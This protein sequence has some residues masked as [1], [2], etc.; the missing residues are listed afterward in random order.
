[1]AGLRST[2]N[3][4]M[5]RLWAV[6]IGVAMCLAACGELSQ[7]TKNEAAAQATRWGKVGRQLQD[8]E[9]N[10]PAANQA[11]SQ[12]TSAFADAMPSKEDSARHE[13]ALRYGR[14]LDDACEAFNEA[15]SLFEAVQQAHTEQREKH[16]NFVQQ[17]LSNSMDPKLAQSQLDTYERGLSRVEQDL[18][19]ALELY[20][21][22]LPSYRQASQELSRL[23]NEF[24]VPSLTP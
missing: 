15:Q 18:E 16:A 6:F 20:Q 21:A 8:L 9:R 10:L 19:K 2:I 3:L 24:N 1:M 5:K 23:T 12:A 11:C 13:A 7:A 14:Q 22:H 17:V 4:A